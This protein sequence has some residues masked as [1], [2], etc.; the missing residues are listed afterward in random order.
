[1]LQKWYGL[2]SKLIIDT[3]NWVKMALRKKYEIL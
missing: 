1:M 3:E 2:S